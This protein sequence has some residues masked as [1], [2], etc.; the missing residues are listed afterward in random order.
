[1]NKI[2]QHRY[3]LGHSDREL[4]RLA[5]QSR[6]IAPITERLLNSA[7][8]C[9]GM[10]VLDIG[11]GAGDVSMLAA[12]MVGASGS[13][14]GVDRSPEALA[15]AHRRARESGLRNVKFEQA[16]IAALVYPRGFDAVIGRYVLVHTVDPSAVLRSLRS[17]LRPGGV[18]AF[19]ELDLVSAL[20]S[21]PPVKVW[22]DLCDWI[23]A[24]FGKTLNHPD[25]ARRLT[26]HFMK[27]GLPAPHLF[28]EIPLGNGDH[29]PLY[30]W[31]ADTA[32]TVRSGMGG[33]LSDMPAGLDETLPDV[34]R[35]DTTALFSQILGPAQICAWAKAD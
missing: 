31:L 34:L 10:N 28:C 20:R 16:D 27:A 18:L 17:C 12:Q 11:C 3:I 4:E 24:N 30:H 5:F 7:G 19:H 6:I 13:V 22:D 8:L 14:T 15:T 2:S 25:A 26:E 35:R 23:L 21:H 1:M 33:D 32:M 29:S 9:E